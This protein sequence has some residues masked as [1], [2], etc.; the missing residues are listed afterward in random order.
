MLFQSLGNSNR[1]H[2]KDIGFNMLC[3]STFPSNNIIK[4]TVSSHCMSTMIWD[5]A[6]LHVE[7]LADFDLSF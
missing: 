3:V 6:Q 2:A 5:Y 1:L 7:I 4:M